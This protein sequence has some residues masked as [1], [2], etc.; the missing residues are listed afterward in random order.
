MVLLF[1]TMMG[2]IADAGSSV[3]PHRETS[4]LFLFSASP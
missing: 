4:G 2:V 3:Y 1:E